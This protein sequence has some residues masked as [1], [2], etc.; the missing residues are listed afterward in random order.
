[1]Q[2]IANQKQN[3]KPTRLKRTQR[4][5]IGGVKKIGYDP[6][7]VEEFGEIVGLVFQ[8]MYVESHKYDPKNMYILLK[9]HYS[10]SPY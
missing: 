6:K 5:C 4:V 10:I 9:W 2:S 8:L 7:T 3:S 1:M